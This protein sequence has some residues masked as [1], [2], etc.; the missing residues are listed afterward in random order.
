VVSVITDC[1]PLLPE[2]D[3]LRTSVAQACRILAHQGLAENI[4]GHVSARVDADIM[5]IRCRGP[6]ERG[7]AVTAPEDIRLCSLDG[8]VLDDPGGEYRPPQELPIH[9]AVYRRRPESGA[10][11]HA[12]PRTVLLAGLAGVVLRPVFGA[13]NIP[14]MRMALAGIPVWPRAVLVSRDD[15]ADQLLDAMGEKSVCIMRGHGITVAGETVAQATVR[16]V[17]LHTLA[18]ICLDLAMLGAK[19]PMITEQ[20][21]VLLPDLGAQFNDSTLWDH[22]VSAEATAAA[23]L[24]PSHSR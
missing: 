12:H 23:R 14:A 24:E 21:L 15:L 11:V 20:D 17:D 22:Y 8:Q 16:S 1:N 6:R 18:D 7:L 2:V 3:E 5:L 10:V 4:L 19:P 9:S 13:Y